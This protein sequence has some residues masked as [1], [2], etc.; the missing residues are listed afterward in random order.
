M[1]KSRIFMATGAFVLAVS[2][3]F[4]TKANKKFA[5]TLSV[6]DYSNKLSISAPA[7]I[8]TAINPGTGF[9]Q[10][11]LALY[12]T[13][14]AHPLASGELTTAIGNSKPVFMAN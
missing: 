7:D 13:A 10:V 11:Y 5:P 1:K 6:V 12:T 9:N 3:V 8:F 14:A 4:A 2:A